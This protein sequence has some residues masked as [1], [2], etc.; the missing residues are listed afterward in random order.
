MSDDR[1]ITLPGATSSWIL[2]HPRSC[3]IDYTVPYEPPTAPV[4][5]SLTRIAA[6]ATVELS[7]QP[8][9]YDGGQAVQSYR[10]KVTT[11]SNVVFTEAPQ[12]SRVQFFETL[13]RRIV[14][15]SVEPLSHC[16]CVVS[17][18][19]VVG[20]GAP[21][22]KPAQLC[23]G[24]VIVLTGSA[25]GN[26]DTNIQG[27]VST[28]FVGDVWRLR[29]AP[30]SSVAFSKIEMKKECM[31]KSLQGVSIFHVLATS[32][33]TYV[34]TRY[35]ASTCFQMCP[36]EHGYDAPSR[37]TRCF[38][39]HDLHQIL[40]AA[41]ST[42]SLPTA[43]SLAN[44]DGRTPLLVAAAALNVQVVHM[45]LDAIETAGDHA[46]ICMIVNVAD[47]LGNTAAH[48]LVTIEA[49]AST[50]TE[51]DSCAILLARLAKYAD[52][53][54]RNKVGET[55][56]VSARL[57]TTHDTP[58]SHVAKQW[59]RAMCTHTYIARP[60][61]NQSWCARARTACRGR[62]GQWRAPE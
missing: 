60:A 10:V 21:S 31:D 20:E 9:L 35:Q 19:N 24:D 30:T 61:G 2:E 25:M 23:K 3:S 13:D 33:D 52:P 51:S 62:T 22:E 5:L 34:S 29:S 56:F 40:K 15:P 38:C 6:S 26:S 54:T 50:L 47:N 44:D 11:A 18:I 28:P 4:K 14:L 37:D 36:L 12:A 8:P 41:E 7:W 39:R 53:L 27:M 57:S 49:S 58:S 1:P 48:H 45:F 43:L 55:V 32:P 16:T 17:A 42:Q 46:T 59:V